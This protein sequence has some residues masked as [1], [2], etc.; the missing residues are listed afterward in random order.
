MS[1]KITVVVILWHIHISNQYIIHLKLVNYMPNTSQ[2]NWNEISRMNVDLIFEF[3]INWFFI[4]ER[5]Q[6]GWMNFRK[7]LCSKYW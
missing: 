2:K 6:I 3:L 4:T 1:N 7:Y 5:L